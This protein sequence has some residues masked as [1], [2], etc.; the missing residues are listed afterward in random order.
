MVLNLGP[1]PARRMF[2]E[3]RSDMR[4]R[5]PTK[6]VIRFSRGAGGECIVRDLS[7]SGAR[8]QFDSPAEVPPRFEIRINGAGWRTAQVRWR[9]GK[10]VGVEFV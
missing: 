1:R 10:D 7:D 4:E 8:L 5:S 9:T 2:N 6:A 3:R